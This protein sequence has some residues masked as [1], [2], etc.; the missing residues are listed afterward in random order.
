MTRT[1]QV[2]RVTLW[3]DFSYPVYSFNIYLTGYDLQTINLYDVF[4]GT[5]GTRRFGTGAWVSPQGDLSETNPRLDLSDCGRIEREI[6][7]FHLARLQTAFT[8]GR[9]AAIPSTN[10]LAC[11]NVGNVHERAVGYITIDVVGSCGSAMPTDPQY[12]SE[13]LRW[14]NALIG[15]YQ[16]VSDSD[17]F[18]QGSPMVHIR[19]IGQTVRGRFV[20]SLNDTFY[21]R[22][23][24]VA[25]PNA[26]GRQPL[27]ATFAARWING[28]GLRTSFKI[29]REGI[30]GSAA[31]C[32]D[33]PYN[34]R[35]P[36]AESVV[37]D[38]DEN[39]EGLRDQGPGCNFP[40]CIG[41]DSVQLPNTALVHVDD[42]DVFPQRL[43]DDDVTGWVYLNL[44]QAES[45][46]K[47]LQSWVIVS[48]RAEGRYSIDMDAAVLGNGCTGSIGASAFSG[49]GDPDVLPGPAQFP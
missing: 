18:A 32:T 7:A 49:H 43:S 40:V 44:D 37:F 10:L 24:T 35:I 4:L 31:A 26:D 5:I 48:M 33:Y 9:V 38:E 30:T 8:E 34:G 25:D 29:W 19:A 46:P 17:N 6:P 11:N 45:Q 42:R 16:Q 36:I 27:P 12:F 28:Q 20:A 15:D 13:D 23:Q 41:D 14:D 2:A 21:R 39:G 3:T 47:P 1:A 22:F